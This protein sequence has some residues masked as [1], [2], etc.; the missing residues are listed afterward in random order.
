MDHILTRE[1]S[2]RLMSLLGLP[3]AQWGNFPLMR[4]AFLTKCK[5]LHPDK[6]GDQEMAKELIGLY[7]R[8]ESSVSA[9]NPD[10]HFSTT[11]VCSGGN[12]TIMGDISVCP[13]PPAPGA[14]CVCLFCLLRDSH[15]E[16]TRQPKVWG[17][18]YCYKCYLLWFGLEDCMYVLRNW[19]FV[20]G[21]IPFASLNI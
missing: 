9:L 17:R 10:S 2:K 20:L 11:Q 16:K 15:G 7:K 21:N 18:C 19:M 14:C 3:M 5:I 6:G 4:K 13:S 8:V 1:E 12:Y